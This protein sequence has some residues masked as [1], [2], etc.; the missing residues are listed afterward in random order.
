MSTM[1]RMAP[2]ISTWSLAIAYG[3]LISEGAIAEPTATKNGWSD[4]QK[5]ESPEN[6]H[7]SAGFSNAELGG[8]LDYS[9]LCEQAGESNSGTPIFWYR[10]D[11]VVT[12]I[13]TGKVEYKCTIDDEII[14]RHVSTAVLDNAP[15]P[16]CLVVRSDIGSGVNIR[17]E[18]SLTAPLVGFLSN[19]SQI[20]IEKNPIY[21]SNEDTGRIW[22]NLEFQGSSAWSSLAAAEGGH[23]NYQ[24]CQP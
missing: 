7:F 15:F 13:G 4:W 5:I 2:V 23:I 9:Y 8:Y 10:L 21:L 16:T 17:K 6:L 18:P 14:A 24:M 22:L 3:C 19:G 1:G 11:N 20:T 12:A